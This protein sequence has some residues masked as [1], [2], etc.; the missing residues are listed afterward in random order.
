MKFVGYAMLWSIPAMLL[1]SSLTLF[2][3]K[4]TLFGFGSS[5]IFWGLLIGGLTLV[6]RAKPKL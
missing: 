5:I 6:I 1:T 3:W 4:A 2:G